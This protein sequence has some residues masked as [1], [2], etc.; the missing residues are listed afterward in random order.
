MKKPFV[1]FLLSFLLAGAGLA[2]LGKWKYAFVNLGVVILI[3]IL[4]A[5]LLSDDT[6][7]QYIR[8]ISMGCAG[9][10]GGY[11]YSLATQMNN[12]NQTDV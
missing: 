3:G 7:E 10:S 8:F 5:T 2:Y 6:F 1:A 11:A 4:A 9:G 12:T